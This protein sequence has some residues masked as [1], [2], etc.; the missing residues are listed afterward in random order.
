MSAHLRPA[1]AWTLEE[2]LDWERQ[3]EAR[4]EFDGVGPVA[5]TGGTL[6]HSIIGSQVFL[7]LSARLRPPC[8]AFR[9]DVKV[10]VAENRIRYPDAV[11][12]CTDPLPEG[13]DILPGP[14]VVFEVLSPSIAAVDRSV[15]AAEYAATPGIRVYVMLEQDAPRATMRRRGAEGWTETAIE[16]EDATIA[17]PEIGI[18]ALPLAECYA[19]RG[20]SPA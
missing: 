5:M 8:R 1:L 15:K 11:V 12:S 13:D 2:F 20:A 9:G 17:L 18:T 16:G 19:P 6:R 7:A 10:Q 4:W 14:V 3:Q